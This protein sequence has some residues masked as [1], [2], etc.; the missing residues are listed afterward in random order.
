MSCPS[1]P[2]RRLGEVSHQTCDTWSA[3]A[4]EGK[5]E[6]GRG[7]GVLSRG[8]RSRREEQKRGERSRGVV[9]NGEGRRG[10]EGV[11]KKRRGDG[12]GGY[13]K[14]RISFICVISL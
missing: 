14:D 10:E 13:L 4:A 1:H 8:E 3:R 6:K 7:R 12:R 2:Y 9:R 11:L 5:S